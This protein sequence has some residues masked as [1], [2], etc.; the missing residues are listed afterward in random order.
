MYTVGGGAGGAPPA[1]RVTVC[2]AKVGAPVAS[3]PAD[4]SAGAVAKKVEKQGKVREGRRRR[5]IAGDDGRSREIAGGRTWS[6]GDVARKADIS[7]ALP[8]CATAMPSAAQLD[9]QVHTCMGCMLEHA[10]H[11]PARRR[12]KAL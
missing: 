4:W 2:D 3:T 1:G 5:E 9:A 11:I 6:V 10:M 12:C 8:S 7:A